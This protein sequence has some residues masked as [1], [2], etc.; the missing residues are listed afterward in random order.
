MY[1]FYDIFL[2]S[3]NSLEYDGLEPSEQLF[4]PIIKYKESPSCFYGYTI[5]NENG[6]RYVKWL[7]KPHAD[8]NHALTYNEMLSTILGLAL[9]TMDLDDEDVEFDFITLK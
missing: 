7:D 6:I 8:E 9:D 2:N 1:G 3:C 5:K 4:V